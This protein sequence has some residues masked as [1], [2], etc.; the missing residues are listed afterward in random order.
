VDSED[1][2]SNSGQVASPGESHQGNGGHVMDEHLPEVF[3]FD[4]EKLETIQY[5][6]YDVLQN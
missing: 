6:Q 3:P 1:Q 5:N 4:I 2:C